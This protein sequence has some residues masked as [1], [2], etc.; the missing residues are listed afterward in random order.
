VHGV[1]ADAFNPTSLAIMNRQGDR[2]VKINGASRSCYI[3]FEYKKI[4]GLSLFFKG[5]P[6]KKKQM[7]IMLK[8]CK[9]FLSFA[10][11]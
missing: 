2:K 7:L 9:E 3:P 10:S 6:H 4:A 5:G 8:F 1:Q 11:K